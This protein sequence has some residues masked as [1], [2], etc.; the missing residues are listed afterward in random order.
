MKRRGQMAS[1]AENVANK[2]VR[3]AEKI[4]EHA[5][6]WLA[7]LSVDRFADAA[8][9][10]TDAEWAEAA[11]RLGESRTPGEETRAFVVALLRTG[12]FDRVGV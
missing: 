6:P 8:A 12:V 1:K 4:H 9:G 5:R 11:G 3:L 7:D 10:M 2:A